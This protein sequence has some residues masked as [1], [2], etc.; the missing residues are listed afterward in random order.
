[1]PDSLIAKDHPL[2]PRLW[3]WAWPG[4]YNL[5]GVELPAGSHTLTLDNLNG[6]IRYDVLV[7]TDE[8]SFCPEDGRLRQS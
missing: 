1:V 2:A 6:E 4:N 7:I 5:E 8:P 3:T